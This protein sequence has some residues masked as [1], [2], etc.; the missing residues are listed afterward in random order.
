[1][2]PNQ[3][4]PKAA[5]SPDSASI[6]VIG[7]DGGR[8]LASNLDESATVRFLSDDGTHVRRAADAGLDAHCVDVTDASSLYPVVEEFE[9][10]IVTVGPDRRALFTAQ[11]LRACC[12]IE[13]V[14]ACVTEAAYRDAFAETGIRFVDPPSLLAGVVRERLTEPES[15]A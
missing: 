6:V 1:M 15:G 7:G 5:L 8:G 3:K 4:R 13:T 9:T 2:V 14:I 12:G 11:L 10:A